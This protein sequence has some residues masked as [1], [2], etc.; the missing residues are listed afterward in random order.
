[1]VISFQIG[2]RGPLLKA[3]PARTVPLTNSPNGEPRSG[4]AMILPLLGDHITRSV[5]LLVGIILVA[6]LGSH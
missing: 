1:M 3:S 4:L 6:G 5:R 2:R